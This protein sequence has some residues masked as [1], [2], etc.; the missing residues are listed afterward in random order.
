MT[1]TKMHKPRAPY[2][3][4]TGPR[5][6]QFDN[7][8]DC[9]SPYIDNPGNLSAKEGALVQ[10]VLLANRKKSLRRIAAEDYAG[11]VTHGD[12]DRVIHGIFPK[13]L[14]KRQALGLPLFCPVCKRKVAKIHRHT[15]DWLKEAVKGL[16]KLEAQ[17]GAKPTQARV[18]TRQG[19]LVRG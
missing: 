8:G 3:R 2:A 18:Y 16:Q 11:E 1:P 15:P 12:L 9:T 4:R 19:K 7:E 14:N 6:V 10:A 17:A 13:D 5:I